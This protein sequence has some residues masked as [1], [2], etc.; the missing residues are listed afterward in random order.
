MKFI[1]ATAV[2]FA[3]AATA[4][5]LGYSVTVS[6]DLGYDNGGR[7][8]KDVACSDGANGMITKG[9]PNQGSIPG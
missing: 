3:A 7:S 5:T 6:Y 1:P 2:L 4:E 8:M 9:Y